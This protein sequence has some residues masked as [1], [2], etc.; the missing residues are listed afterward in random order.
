MILIV[1]L[2]LHGAATTY[3]AL[4]EALK[5]QGTWWHYM[6]WTWL[7][8]TEKSPD[9]IVEALKGHIKGTDRMLVSPLV[10]PYQGLLVPEE[11]AWI[12]ER[13]NPKKASGPL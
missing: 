6:R 13:I 9:Q 11:W 12:R 2:D 10:R 8:E 4:Y 1:N 5:Q 3:D 7:L